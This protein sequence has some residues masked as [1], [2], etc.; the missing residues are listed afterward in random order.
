MPTTEVLRKSNNCI[1]YSTLHTNCNLENAVMSQNYMKKRKNSQRHDLN[2]KHGTRAQMQVI[3]IYQ[4][5]LQGAGEMA[6]LLGA[7][8]TPLEVLSS[9]PS[10]HMLAHNNL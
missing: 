4:N 9:I 1:L 5:V 6:Q 8:P 2:K 10:N 7:R 3:H